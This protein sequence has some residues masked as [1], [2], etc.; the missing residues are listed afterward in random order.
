M[1]LIQNDMKGSP[2]RIM[3]RTKEFRNHHNERFREKGLIDILN[4]F[5]S[6]KY[7]DLPVALGI[8]KKT[9]C[10]CSNPFC[11][12]NPRHQ[13]GKVNVTIPDLIADMKMKEELEEV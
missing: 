6:T 13:R 12:G 2:S 5:G 8:R 7:I 9:R 11:C 4:S 1:Y 10:F 3:K